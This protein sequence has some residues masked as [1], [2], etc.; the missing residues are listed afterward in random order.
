[1][2]DEIWKLDEDFSAPKRSNP[3]LIQSI[4]ITSAQKAAAGFIVNINDVVGRRLAYHMINDTR[5]LTDLNG[6]GSATL[7]SSIKDTNDFKSGVA[8]FPIAVSIGRQ[9]G[10]INVTIAS[11]IVRIFIHSHFGAQLFMRL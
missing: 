2:R 6:P 10:E 8:P 7:W 3:S 9:Q 5:D 4:A 1:M 11:P